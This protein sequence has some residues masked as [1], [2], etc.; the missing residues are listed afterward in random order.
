[1]RQWFDDCDDDD[2]DDDDD[3]DVLQC[4]GWGDAMRKKHH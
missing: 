2:D 1:V 4:F 3:H